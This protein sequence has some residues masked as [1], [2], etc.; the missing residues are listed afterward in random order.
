MSIHEESTV[1][2]E[3]PMMGVFNNLVMFDQHTRQEQPGSRRGRSQHH[4]RRGRRHWRGHAAAGGRL[5]GHATRITANTAGLRSGYSEEL[6][7]GPPDRGEA[8][9]PTRQS[10]QSQSLGAR[11]PLFA[12]FGGDH[13]RPA[14]EVYIDGELETIDTTNWFPRVMR[15]D[16]IVGLTGAGSGPDPDQ[17]LQR[18]MAEAANSTITAIAARRWTD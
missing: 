3:G 9:L 8:R 17:N 18:S 7:R 6:R 13:D 1:F 5:V 2:A 11:S 15:R 10:S 12:R 14:E 4:H 16:F